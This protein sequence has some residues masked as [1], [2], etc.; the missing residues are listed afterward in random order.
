[1]CYSIPTANSDKASSSDH[2]FAEDEW[3]SYVSVNPHGDIVWSRKARFDSTCT[4]DYTKLPYDT[5][6]CTFS[7]GIYSYDTR[8]ANLT[9]HHELPPMPG[10]ESSITLPECEIT[11]ITP[12]HEEVVDT[13]RTWGYARIT[14]HLRRNS[15]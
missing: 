9:W 1:M 15:E 13:G 3:E 11:G 10:W 6:S 2:V 7:V 14:L 12:Y 5:Q 4:M 8:R